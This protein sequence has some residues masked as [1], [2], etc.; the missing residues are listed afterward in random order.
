MNDS[1]LNG[2]EPIYTVTGFRDFDYAVEDIE[3]AMPAILDFIYGLNEHAFD[4]LV[5]PC[6]SD[7][8]NL[9]TKYYE[10]MALCVGRY[11]R[12]NCYDSIFD[13]IIKSHIP[14]SA[15]IL[16]SH[17]RGLPECINGLVVRFIPRLSHTREQNND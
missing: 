17:T 8:Y 16:F 3:F 1:I 11:F 9:K 7:A 6:H 5:L 15:E 13:K 2:R 14:D 10:H 4:V 12:L